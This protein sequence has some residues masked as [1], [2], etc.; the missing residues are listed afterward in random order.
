MRG[1]RTVKPR[2]PLI[3]LCLLA[4][5]GISVRAE[6]HKP[7]DSYLSLGVEGKAVTGRW[8][9]ALRDLDFAIG[10]DTNGDGQIT[11]GELRARHN[12]I[13]SFALARLAV[14]AD[15]KPCSLRPGRHLVDRHTD[16]AYEVLYFG[17]DCLST[18]RRLQVNYHLFFDLD[19]QHKGLLKLDANS[20]TRTAIFGV[21]TQEQQFDLAQASRLGQFL[22]YVREGVL[23]IWAGFDHILFLLSLLLPAVLVRQERQWQPVTGLRPAFL[24]VFKVVTAFTLAH[25]ITLSVATLGLVTPPSRWVESAIA[26]SV[27]F[28]AL[29]NI[30]VF[31]ER[32][33]WVVAFTFG[34]IHG[35]GFASVLTDLGLPRGVLLLG[36]VGFNLGVEAGQLLIVACFLPVAFALR[37][38]WLYRRATL[39]G[40]SIAIALTAALWLTERAF[41]IKL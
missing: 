38:T 7:S 33:R 10:L 32:H 26:A 19:P 3:L 31:A 13:A 22:D 25:S 24:E 17:A 29:S 30:F 8:D 34:L 37:A 41:D 1:T 21:T 11:W 39:V 35:F 27:L 16:G 2:L 4:A 15:G 20:M 6:A 14:A 36:L 5:L 23:H 40:G 28:A 9:I 12:D 18:P